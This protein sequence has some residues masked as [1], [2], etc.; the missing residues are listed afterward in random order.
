MKT[1]TRVRSPSP[2]ST[3]TSWTRRHRTVV[4]GA[5]LAAAWLPAELQAQPKPKET[6]GTY[7]WV[8]A[9]YR[10]VEEQVLVKPATTRRVQVPPEYKT[11]TEQIQTKPPSIRRVKVPAGWR[12]FTEKVMVKEGHWKKT[13]FGDV[14]IPPQYE[15]KTQK[16]WVPEQERDET[17]PAEFKTVTR[18][19]MVAPATERD[20]VVPAEYATRTKQELVRDAGW[21]WKVGVNGLLTLSA[22]DLRTL[23]ATPSEEA[24]K[25]TLK[26]KL[27]GLFARNPLTATKSSE[28]MG[29]DQIR[30]VRKN[31]PSEVLAES[32][33]APYYELS[34]Y[35][36]TVW[37]NDKVVL[38]GIVHSLQ[39]A[40]GKQ[41][42]YLEPTLPQ[43][44]A[45]KAAVQTAVDD[46]AKETS[47]VHSEGGA[48]PPPPPFPPPPQQN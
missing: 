21:E 47:A 20:E 35:T 37:V 23:P 32:G 11:V 13:P 2:D 27:A 46:A 3:L 10:T 45:Y 8:P 15:Y 7:V 26:E 18:Q 41:G 25:R 9:Q 29:P 17:V 24:V 42:K 28:V 1:K 12:N 33:A 6:R 36:I 19:T 5:I 22:L 34:D 40:V 48:K 43:Y 16:K 30:F 4:L 44:D 31:E 38:V 14:W 39:I